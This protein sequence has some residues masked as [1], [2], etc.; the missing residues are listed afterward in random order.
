M[1]P[2]IIPMTPESV[3]CLF[4]KSARQLIAEINKKNDTILCFPH[5]S[6]EDAIVSITPV[7][8]ANMKL[9][10]E[11]LVELAPVLQSTQLCIENK[12]IGDFGDINS[13]LRELQKELIECVVQCCLKVPALHTHKHYESLISKDRASIALFQEKRFAWTERTIRYLKNLQTK[14]NAQAISEEAK[15]SALLYL[16]N[17]IDSLYSFPNENPQLQERIWKSALQLA[18]FY[19]EPNPTTRLF[20]EHCNAMLGNLICSP[21]V[22]GN[23]ALEGETFRSF[24]ENE[25]Y[26]MFSDHITQYDMT[27][28][29]SPEPWQA[30]WE[31]CRNFCEFSPGSDDE[32]PHIAPN[33]LELL[34]RLLN[35]ALRHGRYDFFHQ[36][37]GEYFPTLPQPGPGVLKQ[38]TKDCLH[39]LFVTMVEIRNRLHAAQQVQKLEQ[40]EEL[41]LIALNVYCKNLWN[42]LEPS[43]QTRINQLRAEVAAI[44]PLTDE[45]KV[46]QTILLGEMGYTLL[47]YEQSAQHFSVFDRQLIENYILACLEWNQ[48]AEAASMPDV[49][50]PLSA[51]EADPSLTAL[52]FSEEDQRALEAVDALFL[53][54]KPLV[55]P[56]PEDLAERVKGVKI[57][58]DEGA[59]T[60]TAEPRSPKEIVEKMREQGILRDLLV[61]PETL[62]PVK[63]PVLQEAN[64]GRDILYG[65]ILSSYRANKNIGMTLL[66]GE[67]GDIKNILSAI[68]YRITELSN[69]RKQLEKLT[70][71]KFHCEAFTVGELLEPARDYDAETIGA[72]LYQEIAHCFFTTL[73]VI[74]AVKKNIPDNRTIDSEYLRNV[75]QYIKYTIKLPKH[76][77]PL[78]Y[79]DNLALYRQ[80]IKELTAFFTCFSNKEWPALSEN[81]LANLHKIYQRFA[82]T[83]PEP[84]DHP[85]TDVMAGLFA[86]ALE[87]KSY[88]LVIKEFAS[89]CKQL[90]KGEVIPPHI[91]LSLLFRTVQD[92]MSNVIATKTI[93]PEEFRVFKILTESFSAL[94]NAVSVID[95]KSRKMAETLEKNAKELI[96]KQ[97]KQLNHELTSSK[98]TKPKAKPKAAPKAQQP[99]IDPALLAEQEAKA[100]KEAEDA[101]KREQRAQAKKE[102]K[103]QER[104]KK[105]A[106]KKKQAS[107]QLQASVAIDSASLSSQPQDKPTT[108]AV[109]IES[110]DDE[111]QSLES[112]H[113]TSPVNAHS[114]GSAEE[115]V[116]AEKEEFLDFSTEENFPPLPPRPSLEEFEKAHELGQRILSKGRDMKLIID[117]EHETY[118]RY[119]HWYLEATA[120]EILIHWEEAKKEGA[121]LRKVFHDKHEKFGLPISRPQANYY[122]GRTSTIEGEVLGPWTQMLLE[123]SAEVEKQPST[124]PPSP[125][126]SRR[127]L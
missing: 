122:L 38:Y 16:Y 26:A 49:P 101:H 81:N 47:K 33:R 6:I 43:Y 121:T 82:Q 87:R 7:I 120:K 65:G 116:E 34:G 59:Q 109:D 63:A 99:K 83:Y 45:G 53:E 46:L 93:E 86:Y 126:I 111:T 55:K 117:E 77:K 12:N 97:E 75:E 23:M 110:S 56:S 80:V 24:K 106:R 20:S 9:A 35:T 17:Y 124:Q 114:F 8:E 119:N 74:S 102:K 98:K 113:S 44:Q 90:P 27:P 76:L 72:L 51:E 104:R 118:T 1:P 2:K 13:L 22:A 37:C 48:L 115:A 68:E 84:K 91:D 61:N 62:E 78:C 50:L 40:T 73:S 108:P 30:A 123:R 71:K 107:V 15:N 10:G 94:K 89:Y 42:F 25:L 67:T 92:G 95:K 18:E 19:K 28:P 5:T 57:V 39:T 66:K 70:F 127:P 79:H 3:A 85:Y 112:A 54:G 14:G 31:S 88:G 4:I 41:T 125:V 105:N 52:E 64:K 29:V 11:R 69:T 58:Y 60:L 21:A 103:A 32:F 96:R 100:K 36:W